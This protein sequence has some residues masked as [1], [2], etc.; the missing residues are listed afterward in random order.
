M[1]SVTAFISSQYE[2]QGFVLAWMF[3]GLKTWNF[4]IE[5]IDESKKAVFPRSIRTD[6]APYTDIFI[7]NHIQKFNEC[8]TF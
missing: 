4:R 2:E 3:S 5:S 6:Q 7:P 1:L 8:I